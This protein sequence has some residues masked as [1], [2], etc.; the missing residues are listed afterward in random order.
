MNIKAKILIVVAV[1]L[2]LAAAAFFYF[3]PPVSAPV[4][5]VDTETS[6]EAGVQI[7]Y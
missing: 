5:P 6:T 1:V 4:E 2:V 3:T 7:Q